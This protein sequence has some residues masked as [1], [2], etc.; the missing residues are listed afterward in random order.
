[1]ISLKEEARLAFCRGLQEYLEMGAHDVSEAA[2]K[3]SETG[4]Y[5][6]WSRFWVGVGQLETLTSLM[7]NMKC[8]IE[9]T[10]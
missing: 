1:M 7:K 10:K 5:E 3:A 2:V 8:P 9:E 4:D 6:D